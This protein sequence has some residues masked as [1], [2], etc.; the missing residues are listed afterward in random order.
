[1]C[2][3]CPYSGVVMTSYPAAE[4]ASASMLTMVKYPRLIARTEG[5]ANFYT[6]GSFHE[7]LCYLCHLDPKEEKCTEV[8]RSR[9]N[10]MMTYIIETLD[11]MNW[12]GDIVAFDLVKLLYLV[13]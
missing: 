13:L 2:A 12:I 5:A 7:S 8:F 4:Q 6:N 10:L 3:N 11:W 9:E 1:M